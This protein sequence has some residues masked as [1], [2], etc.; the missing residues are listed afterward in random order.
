MLLMLF[1]CVAEGRRAL[2]VAEMEMMSR[3]HQ[4]TSQLAKANEQVQRATVVTV[5][6]QIAANKVSTAVF[7]SIKTASP[8]NQLLKIRISLT[9]Y[10]ACNEE[11]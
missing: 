8:K 9:Y 11:A 7:L 4:L 6:T 5:E 1:S 3:H 10:V 2:N